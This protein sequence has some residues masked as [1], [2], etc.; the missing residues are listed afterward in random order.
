M[1]EKINFS[2]RSGSNTDQIL[3][4]DTAS[5]YHELHVSSDEVDL[6]RQSESNS[7]QTASTDD[8]SHYQELHVSENE[9]TYQTLQQQ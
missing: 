5:H 8:P 3:T 9:N 1:T 6:P 4:M 2:W 7:E